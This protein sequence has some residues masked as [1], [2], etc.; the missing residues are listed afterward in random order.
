MRN[1][2]ARLAPFLL[3]T[4]MVTSLSCAA[5]PSPTPPVSYSLPQ[6]EYRL[7]ARYTDVFYCD[8]DFYPVARQGQEEKNALEQFPTIRADAAE[9]TAILDHMGLPDRDA[10]SDQEKLLVYREHKKLSYAMQMTPTGNGYRFVLRTGQGQGYRYEGTITPSAEIA[11]LKQETS[12]NTCPICLAAGTSIGTPGGQVP[13]TGIRE[14]MSVW[15]VDTS[16]NRVSAIVLRTVITP[17]PADFR[18]IRLTLSDGRSLTAS[19][20]H[21][22]AED[23]ALSDYAIGDSLDGATLTSLEE[24]DYGAAATYDLLPSGQTG[25]YWANGILLKSTLK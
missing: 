8:P 24:V 7:I 14:G 10:Y 25:L 17:V 5:P 4:T 11:V 15:T 16:G 1:S 18:V 2:S 13:V 23:R 9:F 22:S 12:F 6:L 3:A 19:R 21:P 20:G